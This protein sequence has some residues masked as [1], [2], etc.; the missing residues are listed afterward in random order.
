MKIGLFTDGL[1][2]LPFEAMLDWCAAHGIETI[3]TGTGNFSDA[4]HCNLARL[5]ESAAAREEF[6]SAIARRGLRLVA[7]NCS[8]NLLDPDPLRRSS[9]QKVF[10][11]TVYLAEKLG[12]NT[13]VTMS[14]CPGE[15]GEPGRFPN[16]V[17]CAWQPE[18]QPLIE[19]Q[20]K[21]SVEP[22]WREA[23]KVAADRGVL[24]AIE[25]HP[26]QAAHNT[27]TLLRL[28][29]AGGAAVGANL[30]PSH[31]FWQGM[32]PL[33]VIGALGEAIFHVHAKDC[34]F[35]AD[36][37]ALNGGLETRAAPPRA[38]EHCLPG[39]G[40]DENFWRDFTAALSRIGYAGTLSLE[41]AWPPAE[42]RAGI[43]RAATLLHR[44]IR[45]DRKGGEPIAAV[46]KSVE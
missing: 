41:Y 20:W 35:D 15:P 3:E 42:S 9:S 33:R 22:F 30:D 14:G 32:D 12:L 31:L 36:E 1:R 34:R 43:H 24:L 28:R 45:T 13:V 17:T 21:E 38:W 10:R 27:R 40:H 23:G 39:E 7:L 44:V 11:D 25:M 6:L 46:P 19:W 2:E 18:F 37:M 16:W 8:G 29:A 4:P 5:L 26:G